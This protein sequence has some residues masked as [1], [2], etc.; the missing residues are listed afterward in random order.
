MEQ[1]PRQEEELPD[2][3]EENKGDFFVIKGDGTNIAYQ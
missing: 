3:R 1:Q 2:Q